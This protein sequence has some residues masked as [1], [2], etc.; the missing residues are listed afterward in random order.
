MLNLNEFLIELL[1]FGNVLGVLLVS[2]LFLET[3]VRVV[4]CF[5][6]DAGVVRAQFLL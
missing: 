3:H 1:L 2:Q 5:D 4:V 6:G